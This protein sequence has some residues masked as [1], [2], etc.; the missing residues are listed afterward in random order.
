MTELEKK[1]QWAIDF[2][3]SVAKRASD[4]HV[5]YSGGKDSDILLHIVRKAK[6]P[7]TAYYCN[8][9]IDPP[10]TINHVK[11]QGNVQIIY[12]KRSFYTLIEHRGLPTAFQRFCCVY[13]KERF[14]AENVI[15]GIR[16]WESDRRAQV[17]H[18]PEICFVHKNGQRG[19]RYM[20]IIDFTNGNVTDYIAAEEIKC[21]PLYYDENGR[22]CVER[23][24]GCLGCPLPANH[25]LP[26]FHRYPRMVR[27]WCRAAA[28]YRNTRKTLGTSITNYR[29]EYE[30]FFHNMFNHRLAQLKNQQQQKPRD[31]ARQSLQSIFNI[32]LPQAISPL[33]KLQAKF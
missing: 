18:E 25:N 17:Y 9:T 15:T 20:P 14:I 8:T 28:I 10:G 19:R 3:R 11:Q 26:T 22:F 5:A 33:E 6:I 2:L 12:P 21:H 7:Y 4:L 31:F 29:D 23:R 13:L 16:H 1:E 24:L 32:E 30:Y 27:A